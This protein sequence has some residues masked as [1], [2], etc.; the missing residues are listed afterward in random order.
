MAPT[1][2]GGYIIA[3]SN[4][5]K[6]DSEFNIQWSKPY[7]DWFAYSVIQ[8]SD[9]GY[10]LAGTIIFEGISSDAWL[11][12][13]DSGG[14]IPEFPSW[15]TLPLLLAATLAIIICK[16]RLLPKKSYS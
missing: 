8:T 16:Q 6:I 1:S 12:K 13:T 5:I 7:G 11:I 4:L 15:I 10:A 2:D 3:C 9:G 14:I